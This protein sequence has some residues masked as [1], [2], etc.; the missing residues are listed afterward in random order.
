MLN[1]LYSILDYLRKYKIHPVIIL[2]KQ[3]LLPVFSNAV[4][5]LA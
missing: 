3:L 1:L 2:C 4:T 5:N